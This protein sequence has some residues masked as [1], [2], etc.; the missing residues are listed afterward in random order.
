ME[1]PAQK[2]LVNSFLNWSLV[3][4]RLARYKN[5]ETLFHRN[6]LNNCAQKGPYYCHY[7]AWRLGTW[8]TEDRFVFFDQLLEKYRGLANW[9]KT[10]FLKDCEFGAFWSFLWE[11]QCANYFHDLGHEV[12]WKNSGPDLCVKMD[13]TELFIECTTYHKS[14]GLNEFIDE[15]FRCISP[16]ISTKHTPFNKYSLPHNQET[17]DFLNELFKP[18]L[19]PSFLDS[20]LEEAK[21]KS[22]FTLPVPAGT[23]NFYVILE[24]EK[25]LEF[26]TEQPWSYTGDPDQYLLLALREILSN[27]STQ[28]NI[29]E[30]HPNLLAVNFLLGPDWQLAS[31]IRKIPDIKLP[32]QIDGLLF[33][34]CGIDQT[35]GFSGQHSHL[36]CNK[37]HPASNLFPNIRPNPT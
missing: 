23:E 21:K 28:N 14:F 30:Y 35:P 26:N 19:D 5:I 29:G 6:I 36:Y 22:P 9:N 12:C 33:T 16:S 2:Q 17:N 27:K 24:N 13:G 3:E 20:M 11:L 15:L 31:W 1:E 32:S 25:P 10:S 8:Q 37:N 4:K 34:V 7:M 18:Y